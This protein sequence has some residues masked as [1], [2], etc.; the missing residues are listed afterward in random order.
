VLPSER[1]SGRHRQVWENSRSFADESRQRL[2][3]DSLSSTEHCHR[4]SCAKRFLYYCEVVS[5]NKI[6]ASFT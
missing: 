3:C 6:A 1:R 2:G 4:L 5:C